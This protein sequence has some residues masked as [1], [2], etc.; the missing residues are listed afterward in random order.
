MT[1]NSGSDRRHQVSI[2]NRDFRKFQHECT[3][4]GVSVLL[5]VSIPN[6]DFRKFQRHPLYFLYYCKVK[7]QSLIGILGNFNFLPAATPPW[8]LCFNP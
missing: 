8:L 5:L 2:P 6:R 7:F 1:E 4:L 3:D